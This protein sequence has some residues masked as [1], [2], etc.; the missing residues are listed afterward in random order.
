MNFVKKT[1]PTSAVYKRVIEERERDYVVKDY[2]L[3]GQLFMYATCS[4]ADSKG[5]IK[6]N[7]KCNYYYEDGKKRIDGYFSNNYSLGIW[8]YFSKDGMDSIITKFDE[9]GNQ[10]FL[11]SSFVNRRKN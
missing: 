5:K 6:Y 4:E 2:Y 7:G 8:K 9:N 3:S 10:S 1:S 11:E